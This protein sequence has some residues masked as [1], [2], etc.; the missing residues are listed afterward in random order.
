MSYTLITVATSKQ[1]KYF[2]IP[3][4]LVQLE[5]N[6]SKLFFNNLVVQSV[7]FIT[8]GMDFDYLTRGLLEAKDKTLCRKGYTYPQQR[9]LNF[10]AKGRVPAL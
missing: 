10:T 8:Y 7:Q 6:K 3:I 2:N 9:Q 4:L 5:Y 1:R